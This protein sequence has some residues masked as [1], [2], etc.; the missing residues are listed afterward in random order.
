MGKWRKREAA[1]MVCLVWFLRKPES[2]KIENAVS[3]FPITKCHTAQQT[4]FNFLSLGVLVWGMMV[5]W[6]ASSTFGRTW[7]I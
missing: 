2:L 7:Q 3:S 4:S 5:V 1:A 6:P